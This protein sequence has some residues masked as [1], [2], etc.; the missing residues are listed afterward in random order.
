MQPPLSNPWLSAASN[1]PQYR[2]ALVCFPQGNPFSRVA[3]QHGVLSSPAQL[4]W[5]TWSSPCASICFQH[6]QGPSSSLWG[7]RMYRSGSSFPAP[8]QGLAFSPLLVIYHM[9]LC[10]LCV[11]L[12]QSNHLLWVMSP[13]NPFIFLLTVVGG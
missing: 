12:C 3:P 1:V 10:L 6:L 4:H 7:A 13:R 2:K 9:A 5:I 8:A 11:S